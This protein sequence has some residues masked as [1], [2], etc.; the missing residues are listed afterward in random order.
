MVESSKDKHLKFV[1]E[2]KQEVKLL[3]IRLDVRSKKSSAKQ[4]KAFIK[5]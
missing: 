2:D 1:K 5:R 4:K 3:L